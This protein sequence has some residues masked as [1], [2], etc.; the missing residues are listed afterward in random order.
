MTLILQGN[1]EHERGTWEPVTLDG[2]RTARI[3]CP[4]CGS[5]AY[6]DAH[7]IGPDGMVEPSL[8]CPN[9]GCGF[10]DTVQLVGWQGID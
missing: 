10:H 7:T 1:I 5:V 2:R 3:S 4:D 9:A 8:E 6:A